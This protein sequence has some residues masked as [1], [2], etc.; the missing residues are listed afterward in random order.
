MSFWIIT[1]A[2]SDLTPELIRDWQSFALIP[3]QYT[4]DGEERTFLPVDEDSE[5]LPFWNEMRAGKVAH[6][7]QI[8]LYTYQKYFSRCVEAGHDVL[9]VAFSSGLSGTYQ[10]AE[11]AREAVLE[12]HPDAHI[13]VVD[14]LAAASGQ[15]LLVR[16]AV[17]CRDERGMDLEQTAEWLIS[18]R[19]RIC[20]LFTVDDLTYLM[21]GGRLKPTGAY[22]GNMLNIKPILHVDSE[23]RL[24]PMEKVQGRRRS[25]KEIA[26]RIDSTFDASEKDQTICIL[27][28]DCRDDAECLREQIL[29]MGLPIKNVMIK[30]IGAIIGA[31]VGPGLLAAIYVGTDR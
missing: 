17:R 12:K 28:S 23:G 7:A 21:R 29:K 13:V 1:D 22:L 18:N 24:T 25:I 31:H 2:A 8:S 30:P 15:G 4:I 11:M 20:H 14:S 6:T 5:M 9:Y 16:Y 19:R 3:M 26:K 27:H 10:V